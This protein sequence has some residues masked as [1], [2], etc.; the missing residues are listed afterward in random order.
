MSRLIP[1]GVGVLALY[2]LLRLISLHYLEPSEIAIT[3]NY[4]SG[5]VGHMTKAGWNITPPWVLISKIDTRPVRVCI[6]TSGR[7][8]NCKLVQF[9]PEAYEEFVATEGFRLYWWGNRVSFNLGY[10]EEYRGMKDILRGYAFGTRKYK[11]I[12]VLEDYSSP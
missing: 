9:N 4:L 11:F 7:G 12:T 10:R 2:I 1:T 3:R 8:F 5:D 6:T